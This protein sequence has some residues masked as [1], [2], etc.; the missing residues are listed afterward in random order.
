MLRVWQ[1]TELVIIV[2]SFCNVC[3]RILHSYYIYISINIDVDCARPLLLPATE[4][5]FLCPFLGQT[6]H[7]G[8]TLG[9]L[10]LILKTPNRHQLPLFTRTLKSTRW[11]L[12]CSLTTKTTHPILL[13]RQVQP[14][15]TQVPSSYPQMVQSRPTSY[16]RRQYL[17]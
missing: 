11:P 5:I 17:T 8:W 6:P 2:C 4:D 10:F 13:Q 9:C 1:Y 16:M 7:I 3:Q 15:S 12:I 14:M